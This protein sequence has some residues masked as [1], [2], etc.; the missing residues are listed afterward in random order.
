MR[1]QSIAAAA[2]VGLAVDGCT[3]APNKGMHTQ[4]GLL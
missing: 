4:P 2:I 1:I 3:S